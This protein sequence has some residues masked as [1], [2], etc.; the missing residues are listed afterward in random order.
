M[1]ARKTPF[2]WVGNKFKYID[3]INNLVRN[4]NYNS[5]ID[6]FMG[7]GNILL[8]INTNA[9]KMIGNDKIKLLPCIYTEIEKNKHMYTL[10]DVDIILNRFNRFS[11]K[12]D[13]YIFRDYWNEKYLNDKMDE[14]FIIET[15]LLLKMCSN[16]MVRFNQKEGYFNQGFRGL[17]KKD[18]FFT[19]SMKRL[20]V[21]SVNSLT[22]I[23]N[24]KE[25]DFTSEDFL[26]FKDSDDNNLIILDPP[27]ILRSDMY[28]VDW[29][30]EHE[31]KLNELIMK[32]KNDFIYFNYLE[33][34]GIVNQE[35]VDII[36][37][38]GLTV[39]EINNKTNAGQGR[40]KNT[41]EVREVLITN[42]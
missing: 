12:E 19:E 5:V 34:D 7:S 33:R 13:Y 22:E 17:G 9:N 16:S 39:I 24:K 3:V 10:E 11:K 1:E 29:N 28:T 21:D 15:V 6:M 18:E 40:S 35:L 27:Y 42:I 32:T 37:K 41:I 2:N 31:N 4:K 38:R 20:C 25:F 14:D 23:L 36:K 30:K 8:N 26:N